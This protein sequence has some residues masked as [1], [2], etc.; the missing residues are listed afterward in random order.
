MIEVIIEFE[1]SFRGELYKS[2]TPVLRG[3]DLF[4]SLEYE[5]DLVHHYPKGGI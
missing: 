3:Y 5:K 4:L 2:N 1:Y